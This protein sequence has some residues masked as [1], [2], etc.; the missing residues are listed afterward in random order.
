MAATMLLS[1]FDPLAAFVTTLMVNAR[2]LFYGISML[3]KYNV[4]GFRKIYLI[5]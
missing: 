1:K 3:E 2:H 4:K 5:Y